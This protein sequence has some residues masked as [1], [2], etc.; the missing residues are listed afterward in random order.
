MTTVVTPAMTAG[1]RQAHEEPWPELADTRACLKGRLSVFM[2]NYRLKNLV[3]T[4]VWIRGLS[5]A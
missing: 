4:V 2:V 3:A 1:G 5:V